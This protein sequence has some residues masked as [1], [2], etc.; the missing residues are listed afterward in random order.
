MAVVK[1]LAGATFAQVLCEKLPPLLKPIHYGS[2]SAFDDQ[3]FIVTLPF[4]KA[5]YS[6]SKRG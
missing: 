3:N 2:I 4:D 6:A 5:V 1:V